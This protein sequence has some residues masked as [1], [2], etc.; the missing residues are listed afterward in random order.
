MEAV[1]TSAAPRESATAYAPTAPITMATNPLNPATT[2]HILWSDCMTSHPLHSLGY[3]GARQGRERRRALVCHALAPPDF[4]V[5]GWDYLNGSCLSFAR[6]SSCV[7][8]AGSNC[9][10]RQLSSSCAAKK[11]QEFTIRVFWAHR[12]RT[13]WSKSSGGSL[14]A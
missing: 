1:S 9:G 3:W 6:S 4:R 10:A 8:G 12:D 7:R 11:P 5:G 2:P 13:S 14:A